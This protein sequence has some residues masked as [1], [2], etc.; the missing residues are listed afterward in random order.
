MR[1]RWAP[2]AADDLRRVLDYL[3][4][5]HR[6]QAARGLLAAVGSAVEMLCDGGFD[7]PEGVLSSGDRVRSWRV[8]RYGLRLYY[9]RTDDAVEV[10][11]LYADRQAPMG[12]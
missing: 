9:R 8:H 11:R 4:E 1:A 10:L 2:E 5:R 3:T 7:G 6:Q 12:G